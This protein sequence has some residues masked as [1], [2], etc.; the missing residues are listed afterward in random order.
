MCDVGGLGMS[1]DSGPSGGFGAVVQGRA[2]GWKLD[3]TSQEHG[4]L[5][6]AGTEQTAPPLALGQVL[7]LIPQHACLTAAQFPWYYVIEEGGDKVVDVW[8]PW[9]FW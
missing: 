4:L 8:V 3:R 2:K 6:Y 5:K 9:K 7:P 1:R